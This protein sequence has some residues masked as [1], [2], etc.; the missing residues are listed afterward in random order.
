MEINMSAKD[1]YAT[2]D[3]YEAAFIFT[4][5][6]PLIST[7]KNGYEVFFVFSNL[8]LCLELKKEFWSYQGQVT[9]K[10]YADSLK[11]LKESIFATA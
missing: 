5:H 9:P 8:D 11:S 4:E 3:L 2:K 6:T 1:E 7:Y 10:K